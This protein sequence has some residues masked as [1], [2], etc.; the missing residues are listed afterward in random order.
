MKSSL[1]SED[2]VPR[3]PR[4]ETWPPGADEHAVGIEQPD[5]AV[6]QQAAVDQRGLVTGDPVEGDGRRTRL[7]ELHHMAGTDREVAPVDDGALRALR[8]VG[9]PDRFRDA[10]RTTHHH[11]AL[12]GLARQRP[13]RWLPSS[14]SPVL[15]ATS[16]GTAREPQHGGA[17]ATTTAR[18]PAATTHAARAAHSRP[19]GRYGSWRRGGS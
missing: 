11:A 19:A 8:D 15:A 2:V 4:V 13:G 16:G 12:Q 1:L 10:R 6:G 3:K 18:S 14:S 5:L 9:A 7:V 17:L